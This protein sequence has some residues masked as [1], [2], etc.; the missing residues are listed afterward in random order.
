MK[1]YLMNVAMLLS[2]VLLLS[3][4]KKEPLKTEPVVSISTISNVT[5]NSASCLGNVS[6]DG[7]ASVTS[8][9]ICYSATN[10]TPTT[11]D[12]NAGSGSGIGS[13]SGALTGLTPGTTYNARAYATNSVGTA[14]SSA[15]TFKTL[16]LA[17]VIT[18]IDLSAITSTTATSGGNITNDGGSPVTAR[19][20]CW[21]TSQNPTIADSKTSDG[22]GTGNFTSSITGLSP[23]GTYYVRAYATN[24]IGTA[25]G[26]QV[27]A[28][29]TA[30]L[31]VISTAVA[32]N[33]S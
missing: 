19:G 4:C 16:A 26:N 22:S 31:P 20:V 13:F 25:Y 32:S 7:G 23:G 28:K 15:L 3:T 11:S 8:R 14:Y 33:I 10:P 29:S 2:G 17:P 27:T 6:A 12:G 18:T 21:S 30:V 24:S 5:D 9:G 1:S